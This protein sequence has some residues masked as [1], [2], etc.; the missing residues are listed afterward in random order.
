ML[1][2]KAFFFFSFSFAIILNKKRK[3]A[4]SVVIKAL[5]ITI[6]SLWRWQ[7][8]G[9]T[10]S[11]PLFKR[12][13]FLLRGNKWPETQKWA[14]GTVPWLHPHWWSDSCSLWHRR[15]RRRWRPACLQAPSS[16][17]CWGRSG[18]HAL[19]WWRWA[20]LCKG[21]GK[22]ARVSWRNPSLRVNWWF[23]RHLR[24]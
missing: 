18:T 11:P 8:L 2:G 14:R 6:T 22:D 4:G 19:G 23:L 5:I 12:I 13:V 10:L 17:W 15:S 9:C 1:V 16:S 20:A 21:R 24:V 3:K 7:D